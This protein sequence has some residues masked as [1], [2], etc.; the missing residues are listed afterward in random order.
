MPDTLSMTL[1]A[2]EIGTM[3]SAILYGMVTVQVYMYAA[4]CRADRAW[5]KALVAFIWYVATYVTL[6]LY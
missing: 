6:C 4:G 1:G 3:V 5:T 2:I